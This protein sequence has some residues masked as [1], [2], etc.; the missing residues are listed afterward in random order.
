[1]FLL[2]NKMQNLT[3]VEFQFYIYVKCLPVRIPSNCNFVLTREDSRI[4]IPVTFVALHVQINLCY[5]THTYTA[6]SVHP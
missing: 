4:N 1:M 3:F 6:P 5:V 2:Q